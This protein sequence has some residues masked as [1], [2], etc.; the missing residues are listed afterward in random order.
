MICAVTML[1]QRQF[2]EHLMLYNNVHYT[3][4]NFT[5]VR[6]KQISSPNGRVW[7]SAMAHFRIS[8]TFVFGL[9]TSVSKITSVPAGETPDDFT[10]LTERWVVGL[11][12]LKAKYSKPLWHTST[13]LK[14]ILFYPSSFRF[15]IFPLLRSY[16][17]EWK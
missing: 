5:N 9:Y 12:Y 17:I 14:V 7:K 16:N 10:D 2:N 11:L 15:V 8:L 6:V 4:L 1:H 3:V 13:T